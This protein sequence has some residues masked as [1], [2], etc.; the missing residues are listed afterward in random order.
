MYFHVD[1]VLA[2]YWAFFLLGTSKDRDR[3]RPPWTSGLKSGRTLDP[4]P[5]IA[6][7]PLKDDNRM[8]GYEKHTFGQWQQQLVV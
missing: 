4:I 5:L 3:G 8:E 1:V 7:D 2:W 6:K